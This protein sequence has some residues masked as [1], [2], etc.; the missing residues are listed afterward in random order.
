MI[1]K[2]KTLCILII[3]CMMLCYGCIDNPSSGITT[4]NEEIVLNS[5]FYND[6][7]VKDALFF[8]VSPKIKLVEAEDLSLMKKL[9]DIL[10]RI[11]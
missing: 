4:H 10:K 1:I 8:G 3:L 11:M 7:F 2:K 5:D 6:E 9:L